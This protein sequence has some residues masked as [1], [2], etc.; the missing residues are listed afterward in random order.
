MFTDMI[1]VAVQQIRKYEHGLNRLSASPV[2]TDHDR[3]EGDAGVLFR[4][5]INSP[6]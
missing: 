1:G 4:W 6:Q 2:A 5:S 3:A